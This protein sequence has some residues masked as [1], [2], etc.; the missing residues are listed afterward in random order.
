VDFHVR[1]IV[2]LNSSAEWLGP[3]GYPKSVR[4]IPI[5]REARRLH[6]LQATT[7]KTSYGANVGHYVVHYANG[8]RDEIPLVYGENLAE[9]GGPGV[10][11]HQSK[12]AWTDQGDPLSGN[13]SVRLF[14]FTW[15]NPLPELPIAAIT[16]VSTL[17]E[18]APLLAA[19]TAEE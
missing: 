10:N 19:L 17:T 7:G 15:L 3:L 14:K 6:F 2:H 16:F 12:L 11:L 13:Q 4:E 9:Y 18:A 5:L 8:Q 1:G